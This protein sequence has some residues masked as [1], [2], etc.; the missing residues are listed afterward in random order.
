[1]ADM[2][3][4]NYPTFLTLYIRFPSLRGLK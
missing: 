2:K 1:M 3:D 4:L